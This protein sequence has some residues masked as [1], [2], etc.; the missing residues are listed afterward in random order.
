MEARQTSLM[1]QEQQRG[2][3]GVAL[4]KLSRR[5]I[6][7]VLQLEDYYP[8]WPRARQVPPERLEQVQQDLERELKVRK[9]F[10]DRRYYKKWTVSQKLEEYLFAIEA[11]KY[12]L[13]NEGYDPDTTPATWA[14]IQRRLAACLL[15]YSNTLEN[16]YL[17]GQMQ[18]GYRF[19]PYG[20]Q[21]EYDGDAFE[22]EE[23]WLARRPPPATSTTEGDTHDDIP[24]AGE[25]E[26]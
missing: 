19:E 14:E 24:E 9:A 15:K 16:A 5:D 4:L 25:D 11:V 22:A 12:E 8:R 1:E 18:S 17:S 23:S 10:G 3:I 20:Y 26:R 7:E 21:R 13:A 6:G 2:K